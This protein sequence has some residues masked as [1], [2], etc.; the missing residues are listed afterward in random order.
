MEAK[1]LNLE[2]FSPE[3]SDVLVE[4]THCETCGQRIGYGSRV[5]RG[6]AHVMQAI[7]R[8]VK[9]K[10]LNAVHIEKEL[11]AKGILTKTQ[12][13]NRTHLVRLGLIIDLP[14]TGNYAITRRGQ[15]FLNG[16]PV[17]REA[18]TKK[19][20][21]DKHSHTLFTSDETITIHDVLKKGEY[22]EVPGF[23]ISEGRVIMP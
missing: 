14:E 3:E 6:T 10:N 5:S 12:A 8:R 1:N 23:T 9:E 15:D 18:F 4:N 20:T 16:K 2:P 19:T 21:K 22:W 7:Y 11:M 13:G 17:P